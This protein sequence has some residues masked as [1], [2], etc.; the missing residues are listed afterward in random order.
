MYIK[1]NTC[2][3]HY[4]TAFCLY[5]IHCLL[6]KRFYTFIF[7]FFNQK[8]H[9]HTTNQFVAGDIGDQ[10]ETIYLTKG[11][12]VGIFYIKIKTLSYIMKQKGSNFNSIEKALKILLQFQEDRPSWGVRELSARLGFSPA[13]VQR[14][15]QTLKAH[16]FVYQNPKTRQ[17]RLGNIYFQFLDTLQ[18]NYPI[19]RTAQPYMKRL[20]SHTQ[21]T[22]HLN[23]IDDMDR[24]CIDNIESPRILKATMP[25]GNRS[26]LY[27]G[28]SSKCLLAFSSQEFIER[29]LE[30]IKLEPLTENTIINITRL[31]T[32]LSVIKKQG[33]A[34]SIG[35][36]TSGL[37]SIS[38]PI[39]DHRGNILAALSIA[40][41]EVRF[42]DL[43]HYEF[44]VKE[45]LS[46]AK[47]FSRIMGYHD[48]ETE[49]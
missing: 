46:V 48:Q 34:S 19:T 3:S 36:R 45:L 7:H 11:I 18:S 22:I 44:C 4:E 25:I 21:E 20:S 17:Y 29:Y 1:N 23:V 8:I 2:V 6:V 13:T 16:C 49:N 30:N 14:I 26:P 40:L 28:G 15:L 31:I 33:F 32:E 42:R 38:A 10:Y 9:A 27:A 39:L 43:D 35:E 24:I 12:F 41:P 5:Q 37:G 47:N